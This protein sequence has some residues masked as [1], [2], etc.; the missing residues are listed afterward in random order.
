MT[1]SGEGRQGSGFWGSV[2]RDFEEG[3]RDLRWT[4]AFVENLESVTEHNN[5]KC[6]AGKESEGGEFLFQ[7]RGRKE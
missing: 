3:G 6:G 4:K 5:N 2:R 1:Y 7:D